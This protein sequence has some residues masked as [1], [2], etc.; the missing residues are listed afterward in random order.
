[1]IH[2]QSLAGSRVPYGGD[3]KK[4]SRAIDLLSAGDKP[5]LNVSEEPAVK[6][7]HDSIKVL[8]NV[9]FICESN[10]NNVL[11][12][13]SVCPSKQAWAVFFDFATE[14]EEA[15]GE[16]CRYEDCRVFG[17]KV[18]GH[19][20][21]LVGIFVALVHGAE[22]EEIDKETVLLACDHMC[23]RPE[24]RFRVFA[25]AFGVGRDG[26]K[27]KLVRHIDKKER[28]KGDGLTDFRYSPTLS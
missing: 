7:F 8:L 3:P 5:A 20:Y 2:P 17:G 1:M 14:I 27:D 15:P 11:N 10:T 16:G 4:I 9:D 22:V 24:G 25:K 13:R 21:R 26:L 28:E 6:C 18:M 19:V 12:I 23:W